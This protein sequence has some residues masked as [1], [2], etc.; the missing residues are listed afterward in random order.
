MGLIIWGTGRELENF[1][2]ELETYHKNVEVEFIATSGNYYFLNRYN[3]KTEKEFLVRK[4]FEFNSKIVLAF[5]DTEYLERKKQLE[6]TGYREFDDFIGYRMYGKKICVINANCYLSFIKKFLNEND[7]F[8]KVYGI[9]PLPPIHDNQYNYIGD[10][11]LQHADLFIHQD[12]RTDNMYSYKFS[13]EYTLK[14][15]RSVKYFLLI[16]LKMLNFLDKILLY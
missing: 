2:F 13:D 1:I 3:V 8:R 10:N 14:K 9:Y 4:T 12:I 7:E 15:I 5:S 6:M 16:N 11:V